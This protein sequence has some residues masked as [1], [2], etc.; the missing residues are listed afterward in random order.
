MTSAVIL[1]GGLG[2]RLRSVVPDLPKPMAPI[3]LKPFLEHQMNYWVDQGVDHFVLSVGYKHQIILEYFGAKFNG[4]PVE[5]VIEALPLGT[6]GA[7]MLAAEK[8]SKSDK[9]LL[10]N[11]DTYFAVS[12]KSLIDFSLKNNA[13]WTFSL[14]KSNEVGRYMG[15][16][17]A[18]GG[19]ISS[20]KS[21]DNSFSKLVNGGVYLVNPSALK[22]IPFGMGEKI[23]LEDDIFPVAMGLGQRFFGKEFL[24][25]F[26]DIGVPSDYY[27]ASA[28]L[29]KED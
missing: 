25:T 14:F 15:L 23:S 4:I 27:R 3:N 2:A 22:D 8:I 26:I 24:N 16:E 12:L 21:K 28:L 6:G 5:Y 9:F 13:D 17:V 10:L 18:P 1:A 20:L 11:G 19:R 29:N 7:L